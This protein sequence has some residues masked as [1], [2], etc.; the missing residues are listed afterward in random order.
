MVFVVA[1]SCLIALSFVQ[2]TG[3]SRTVVALSIAAFLYVSSELLKTS[4]LSP[5]MVNRQYLSY[6]VWIS[7]EAVVVMTLTA[8]SLLI[9][10]GSAITFL[11]SFAAARGAS[12]ILFL[13]YFDRRFFANIDLR[14]AKSRE[15]KALRLW[16][17]HQCDGP[18]GLGGFLSR[19]LH[20][21]RNRWRRT[22]REIFCSGW[23]GREAV[24][25]DKRSSDNL[26]VLSCILQMR[27]Q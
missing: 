8:M 5:M 25:A 18:A 15:A 9:A 27:T 3:Q 23:T 21:V 17:A 24:R 10:G 11:L 20:L 6:S 1:I 2:H 7:G 22:H 12:T 26:F 13:L 4:T 14:A 19:P 16:L